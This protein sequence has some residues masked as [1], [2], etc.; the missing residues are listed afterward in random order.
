MSALALD[1]PTKR[2]GRIAA[3]RDALRSDRFD[4][5]LMDVG[6]VVSERAT[7]RKLLGQ[8][9]S[10]TNKQAEDDADTNWSTRTITLT[11]T[12]KETLA[13]SRNFLDN[14]TGTRWVGGIQIA[15]SN[16]A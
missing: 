16:A 12:G 9:S 14:F 2:G 6:I 13:G 5:P 15:P 7:G 3:L 8:G 11:D 1:V 10:R 4:C